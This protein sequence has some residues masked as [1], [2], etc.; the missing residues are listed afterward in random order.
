MLNSDYN[1]LVKKYEKYRNKQI[2][3]VLLKIILVV[4]IV[5]IGIYL[6]IKESVSNN[7]KEQTLQEQEVLDDKQM[8][9]KEPV[10]KQK[11]DNKLQEIKKQQKPKN[12]ETKHQIPK[13]KSNNQQLNNKKVTP[14]NKTAEQNPI[15]LQVTKR[16]ELVR[17]LKE[18]EKKQNFSTSLNL[19]KYYFTNGRY[20]QS[21]KWAIQSSKFDS[22]ASEP[23][24]LYAKTKQKQGRVKVAIQALE[25]YLKRY[26]SKEAQKL[27][28]N[29]KN[30]SN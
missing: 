5:F 26:K 6:F 13:Q 15:K 18:Y 19:A 16:E 27:L 20:Q 7:T 12:T 28:D 25:M 8:M 11:E 4:V 1:E 22:S 14:K 23:W 2:K 3:S 10:I 29:L 24:I 17:L 30:T 9:Q 21:I